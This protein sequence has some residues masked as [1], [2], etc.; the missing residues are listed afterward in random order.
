MGIT[1]RLVTRSS[2]SRGSDDLGK[3]AWNRRALVEIPDSADPVI[4]VRHNQGKSGRNVAADEKH[5]RE[6]LALL[7]S[8]QIL[9]DVQLVAGQKR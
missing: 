6:R 9:T 8:F 4:T 3:S 5:G 1:T 2:A 7:N